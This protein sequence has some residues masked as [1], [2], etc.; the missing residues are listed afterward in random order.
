MWCLVIR[1]LLVLNIYGLI[2][3]IIPQL[4]TLNYKLKKKTKTLFENY[5]FVNTCGSERD[6]FQ[7]QL[8]FFLCVIMSLFHL[9]SNTK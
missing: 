2:R 4:L 6:S 1:G 8:Y 9:S 5:N 7:S 3:P